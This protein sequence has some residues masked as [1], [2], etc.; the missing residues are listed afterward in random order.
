[1]ASGKT[2]DFAEKRRNL[3]NISYQN[4]LS[5][6]NTF[7]EKSDGSTRVRRSF[8]TGWRDV[9]R[10]HTSSTARARGPIDQ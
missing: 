2:L 7:D 4:I 1:M 5:L 9:V 3:L 10:K 8:G 6:E